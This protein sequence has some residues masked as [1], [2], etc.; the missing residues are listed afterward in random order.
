[1]NRVRAGMSQIIIHV[2]TDTRLSRRGA[3]IKTHT[4]F[5]PHT[6]THSIIIG[7]RRFLFMILTARVLNK[8]RFR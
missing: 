8:I 4:H 5:A 7:N 2:P 6:I 1:V 3:V